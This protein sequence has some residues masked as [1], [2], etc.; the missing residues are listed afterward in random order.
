SFSQPAVG[1]EEAEEAG[2]V[3]RHRVDEGADALAMPPAG[4]A[5]RGEAVAVD[6][7]AHPARRLR[8]KGIVREEAANPGV[9]AEEQVEHPI[10]PGMI[11]RRGVGKTRKPRLPV[12]AV[13]PRRDQ[14]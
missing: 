4:L 8:R 7:D 12:E 13:V 2:I 9:A 3:E 1:P 14:A 6:V 10:D 11:L 5:E